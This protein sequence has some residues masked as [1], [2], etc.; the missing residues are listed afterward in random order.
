M[1]LLQPFCA[2]RPRSGLEQQVAAPPYD[3]LNSAEAHQM[4]ADNP[5]SFLHVSKA[6]ID[7]ET[8]ISPYDDRV[9]ATAKARF[10]ALCADGTLIQDTTPCYYIYL[11]VINDSHQVGIAAAASVEAYLSERIKKHEFTRPDK[12]NDRTR[13]AET[14]SAHSGPVF[15]TYRHDATIDT[16][17]HQ[18]ISANQP[19]YDFTADDAIRHTLW[20]VSDPNA[21]N[22]FTEA[23]NQVP[24]LYIADGHHRAA[25][26]ARVYQARQAA[27]PNHSPTSPDATFLTV[28]FP[29]TQVHILDYNRVVRDLNGL[30]I[31]KFLQQ[32]GETF[33]LTPVTTPLRPTQRHEFGMYLKGQ[34]Y[35]LQ[36]TLTP[37]Q[38]ADPVARLDVTILQEKLLNPLL[39]ITNP[40]QDTRID[41]VGGIRGLAELSRRV[42]SGEM[43]VAFALFPTK[44]DELMAVAD[45]GHVM[46]P[47]STWFEPKLRDG[48]VIQTF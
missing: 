4:A 24:A 14:L 8:E 5:Y 12:E 48:L 39:G 17:T 44:L 25:A 41:F 2:W 47:K 11:L 38:E 46:P 27:N 29:D 3:V 21:V 1:T 22:Q 35:R 23:F 26:A 18:I 10:Q 32:V 43:Q 19:V 30:S 20:V 45:A 34:W 15:L 42:D 9:Y 31:E 28:T 16:L 40:R 33:Q 36:T 13:L 7:L 37:E 6:E